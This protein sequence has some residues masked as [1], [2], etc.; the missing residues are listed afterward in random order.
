M[1]DLDETTAVRDLLARAAVGAPAGDPVRGVLRRRAQ[2]RARLTTAGVTAI[3]AAVALALTVDVP[4]LRPPF[5]G[6]AG[7]AAVVEDGVARLGGVSVTVPPGFS[8]LVTDDT[9]VRP[10]TVTVLPAA[11]GM[12]GGRGGCS[13][14]PWVS[15]SRTAQAGT[16]WVGS[17][18]PGVRSRLV[19]AGDALAWETSDLLGGDADSP[20]AYTF[21]KL[22]GRGVFVTATGTERE[23]AALLAGV[24][25]TSEVPLDTIPVLR[26]TDLVT[27]TYAPLN[28]P[29]A[30]TTRDPARLARL[31]SVLENALHVPRE[32]WCVPDPANLATLDVSASP[33]ADPETG[34]ASAPTSFVVGTSG[35]CRLAFSS[36]GAVVAPDPDALAEVFSAM[37]SGDTPSGGS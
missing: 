31:R 17:G 36:T 32:S 29:V 7:P 27:A 28:G 35:A 24:R 23:R 8:A 19:L 25:A 30:W 20:G 6:V 11:F 14:G 26:R 2:A 4:A 18:G 13:T 22:P 1:T 12:T 33:D 16:Q 34:P 21:W 5:T 10:R 37:R 3:A 15:L 9:C